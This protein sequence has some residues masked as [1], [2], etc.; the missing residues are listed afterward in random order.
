MF[1]TKRSGEEIEETGGV[2]YNLLHI[3]KIICDIVNVSFSH[4]VH[5][6]RFIIVQI[7]II[8]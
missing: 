8:I 7:C 2:F 3:I 5:L 6:I 4:V 1:L